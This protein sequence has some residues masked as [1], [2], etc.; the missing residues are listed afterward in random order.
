MAWGAIGGRRSTA[1]GGALAF[2][3]ILAAFPWLLTNALS[4]SYLPHGFC[5]AWNPRLL[6]LHVVADGV[7][8]LS[9]V[10]IAAALAELYVGT[11]RQMRFRGILVL[12]SAFIV[13]CGFTHL[14]DVVVLWRPFYW[15]Q[16][17][18]KLLTACISLITAAM[19][20]FCIPQVK[21]V[22]AQAAESAE[23][24]RRFL[25][26]VESSLDSLYL[27]RSVRNDA[28]EI[29]D[30]RFL[31]V[32]GRAAA[33]VSS[34]PE[35]LVGNLLCETLPQNRE[36]GF[37]D[38][39]KQVT[40]TGT[41]YVQEFAVNAFQGVTAEWLKIQV[42]KLDDGVAVT[43]SDISERK[44]LQAERDA[45]FAGSLIDKVPAAVI[46]TD[47][48]HTIVSINPAAEKML[49]Y[50]PEELI[51]AAS[52]LVIFDK[53]QV[54]ALCVR[55][56]ATT[57]AAV[58]PEEAIFSGFTGLNPEAE[59]EWKF[60]RKG[61][62]AVDVQA[63]ITPLT[64]DRM[65]TFGYMIT[66]YD[67]S[68]RKRREQYISH[69]ANHDV[70]TRLPTR[71]LLLDRLK[72]MLSRCDRFG[73][74]SALIM[75]DLNGFKQ[76]NDKFGHHVGDRL[77]VQVAERLQS[78]VRAVDT[79][80]RMGGDEFVVL[81]ADLDSAEG[82]EVVAEKLLES[83]R[84]PFALSDQS[85]GSVGASVGVCVYPAGG[86]DADALLRNADIAMYHAK[87]AR[88]H[89]YRIFDKRIEQVVLQ[90]RNMAAALGSALSKA[91]LR[92]EYQPQ[93]SLA[94]GS[95]V[96]VE[97]LLRWTS[98]VLGPV[99]PGHFI[100][101][102]EESGLILPIGEWVVETAC[103]ELASLQQRFGPRM[104][105]AV[106][107]SARQ[108]DQAGLLPI[109]Q[110]AAKA[111]NIDPASIEI[112]ITESLLMNET[113]HAF[114]FFDGLR[115]MGARVAIDDFGTGFSSMS[116]LLRYSVDRLKIDR[117]FIEDC[118]SNPNSAAITSAVIALAHQLKVS[119]LAEGVETE[120]QMRFLRA[121]GCDDVQ[122][123]YTGRPV[124]PEL[125]CA[126]VGV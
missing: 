21:A 110:R 80:A 35:R 10:A 4:T 81:V 112:E 62:S 92:L 72:M 40:E 32:N 84:K 83:F 46:V 56:S 47:S 87:A 75:V 16:G 96:G 90:Q 24:G 73:K 49:W 114:D 101:M 12:F 63:A 31:F 27:L 57:G 68:E 61:G 37:F 103:R 52:P 8:W 26:A 7:I 36:R 11:Q 33:L 77:L 60:R 58:S 124:A 108:L 53:E 38:A 5:F 20:P 85:K 29:V 76:I 34:T 105:M 70:L 116:Y 93:F 48:A 115:K 71:Q 86:E 123:F 50:K 39:Y 95:L 120:E 2:S 1:I 89:C 23:N 66:A 59:G 82:A 67:I 88:G 106:N 122:G 74:K 97:A 118:C 125:L 13:A 54:D 119:V 55:L 17:D 78:A 111:N 69:L 102:A 91:E 121:A 104:V 51:G 65:E 42:V 94:D 117:C 43:C 64:N 28:G 126:E 100:P 45:A 3:A 99:S 113:P 44:R 79:V 15:M 41:P 22:L 6:W 18:M 30:F 109:I 107:I 19:L 9:Y 25:A 98:G 14:L